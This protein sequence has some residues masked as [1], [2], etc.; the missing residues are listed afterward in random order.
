MRG[1]LSKIVFVLLE[2][3]LFLATGDVIAANTWS[4]EPSRCFGNS[5]FLI[6]KKLL[7]MIQIVEA[8]LTCKECLKWY[9]IVNPWLHLGALSVQVVF[10]VLPSLMQPIEVEELSYAETGDW[11][12]FAVLLFSLNRFNLS[13]IT[14]FVFFVKTVIRALFLSV[15]MRIISFLNFRTISRIQ[16]RRTL[17]SRARKPNW[18]LSTLCAACRLRI[19]W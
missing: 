3:D 13:K 9:Q 2:H 18:K 7:R 4:I 17:S 12:T 8:G 14:I 11:V 19:C 6:R 15:A 16:L 1:R 10:K 5:E